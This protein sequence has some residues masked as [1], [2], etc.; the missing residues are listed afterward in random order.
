VVTIAH[1]CA[2]CPL[3]LIANREVE[4]YPATILAEEKE[5]ARGLEN[6][7][8]LDSQASRAGLR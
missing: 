5:S 7:C 3:T 8:G 6:E 4:T 2:T 1:R